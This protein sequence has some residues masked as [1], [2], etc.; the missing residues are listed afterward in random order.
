MTLDL[1]DL[2][3]GLGV[4]DSRYNATLER[5]KQNALGL[6]GI[7]E[8][9]FSQMTTRVSQS[10][11][12][13]GPV[14]AEVERALVHLEQL[15]NYSDIGIGVRVDD[16]ALDA[17]ESRIDSL[18]GRTI[19]LDV[20]WGGDMGDGPMGLPAPRPKLPGGG[21]FDHGAMSRAVADGV[22]EGI[23]RTRSGP[24]SSTIGRLATGFLEE[25]G[26][27]IA[28][29]SGFG[30]LSRGSGRRATRMAK[31]F[32][33]HAMGL[34]E[35][36]PAFTAE[37]LRSGSFTK[38]AKAGYEQSPAA[39]AMQRLAQ[40][41]TLAT[42]D[43]DNLDTDALMSV[44]G[45][46]D[47][48][49]SE[50]IESPKYK[51]RIAAEGFQKVAE[52]NKAVRVRIGRIVADEMK[53]LQDLA[54]TEFIENIINS[55]LGDLR[56]PLSFIAKTR[57]YRNIYE[58]RK[59]APGARALLPDLDEGQDG[60]VQMIGGA[61]F[62]DGEGH[63]Q[64]TA[65]FDAMLPDRRVM[66]VRNPDTDPGGKAKGVVAG[67]LED[68]I[69]GAVPMLAQDEALSNT[70]TNAVTM[71]VNSLNIAGY[72]ETVASALANVMA[73][74]EAGLDPSKF[75]TVSY[76]LGGAN[77]K[78]IAIA[79]ERMGISSPVQA[80]AYPDINPSATAGNKNFKASLIEEDP[81]GFISLLGIGDRS[82]QQI[83][84]SG[85]AGGAEAHAPKHYF[86]NQEQIAEFYRHL[87]IQAPDVGAEEMGSFVDMGSNFYELMGATSQIDSLVR[88]GGFDETLP[89]KAFAGGDEFTGTQAVMKAVEALTV[90]GRF[91]SRNRDGSP[92]SP[93]DQ[94]NL[95]K[96]LGRYSPEQQAVIEAMT[97]HAYT[98]LDSL[99]ASFP[100]DMATI[101]G[102]RPMDPVDIAGGFQLRNIQS[103]REKFYADMSGDEIG[104]SSGF[105]SADRDEARAII[106]RLEGNADWFKKNL[107]ETSQLPEI[108]EIIEEM[109]SA[110]EE[111]ATTGA[112]SDETRAS[113][114]PP[115]IKQLSPEFES[116]LS[117]KVDPTKLPSQQAEFKFDAPQWAYDDPGAVIAYN[118]IAQG[119]AADGV[120]QKLPQ[121]QDI[122]FAAYGMSGAASL[123]AGDYV[124]K[125]DVYDADK[126]ASDQEVAAYEKLAG[127]YAPLLMAHQQ[128]EY[129]VT[130]RAKGAPLK[131]K[132]TEAAG[133]AKAASERVKV[134]SEELANTPKEN[135]EAIKAG[136]Q[137]LSQAKEELAQEKQRFNDYAEELYTKLGQLG[138]TLHSMGVAHM[139]LAAGNAFVGEDGNLSAIDLGNSLVDPTQFQKTVD[140]AT[141]AQRAVIDQEFWGIMDPVR[142]IKAVQAG[143]RMEPLPEQQA[144]VGRARQ[145]PDFEGEKV[146]PLGSE[147]L[148]SIQNYTYDY[149]DRAEQI[150]EQRVKERRAQMIQ[151]PEGLL[152]AKAA[153]LEDAL[154]EK[155]RVQPGKS[156]VARYYRLMALAQQSKNIASGGEIDE[157]LPI[158]GMGEYATP[159]DMMLGFANSYKE[160][161]QTPLTGMGSQ[162]RVLH[163]AVLAESAKAMEQ[164]QALL[165]SVDPGAEGV[166]PGNVES[167]LQFQKLLPEFQELISRY[168]QPGMDEEANNAALEVANGF[169]EVAEGLGDS[170]AHT[171]AIMGFFKSVKLLAKEFKETGQVT[172]EGLDK[173]LYAMEPPHISKGR[174][175]GTTSVRHETRELADQLGW[176]FDVNRGVGF[177]EVS[178]YG[179]TGRP[180]TTTGSMDEA[181]DI[182]RRELQTL[183]K[184]NLQSAIAVETGDS[185]A[186]AVIE[187]KI[188]NLLNGTTDA[189]YSEV[190]LDALDRA[191][192]SRSATML[193]SVQP[194]AVSE[195]FEAKGKLP[196]DEAQAEDNQLV[197]YADEESGIIRRVGELAKATISKEGDPR[198]I[199]RA[200][201]KSLVT[202]ANSM[203]KRVPRR[204]G[205]V[206]ETAKQITSLKDLKITDIAKITRVGAEDANHEALKNILLTI[207]EL[208]GMESAVIGNSKALQTIKA[209][210]QNF[211]V[212]AVMSGAMKVASPEFAAAAGVTEDGLAQLIGN[213]MTH[214]TIGE[215]PPVHALAEGAGWFGKMSHF[216]H[217]L[218]EA[219]A[220]FAYNA[221]SA[222]IHEAVSGPTHLAADVGMAKGAM[223]GSGAG[224]LALTH[225]GTEREIDLAAFDGYSRQQA[226]MD[227][228]R[229]EAASRGRLS[230]PSRK[231]LKPVTKA[232]D[233]KDT[234]KLLRAQVEEANALVEVN[235]EK[236]IASAEMLGD[237][238]DVL[239][240]D[241]QTAFERMKP[242]KR[243]QG[244]GAKFANLK[245]QLNRLQGQI[246]SIRGDAILALPPAAE[247]AS[248][249]TPT[250][251]PGQ[252][253][254]LNISSVTKALSTKLTKAGKTAGKQKSEG[255]RRLAGKQLLEMVE[256]IET[257]IEGLDAQLDP[258]TE[259]PPSYRRELGKLRSKIKSYRKKGGKLVD[260]NT[261]SDNS[262]WTDTSGEI[263]N[264]FVQSVEGDL[265]RVKRAGESLGEALEGG[266][267]ESLEIQS[268]SKVMERLG[269]FAVEGLDK[270]LRGIDGIKHL[271]PE[272]ILKRIQSTREMID[273]FMD[274]VDEK[275]TK[276]TRRFGAAVQLVGGAFAGFKVAQFAAA[277]LA[278]LIGKGIEVAETMER[279]QTS[280]NFAAGGKLEGAADMSFIADEAD[281]LNTNLLAGA[282]NYARL[283]ATNKGTS[284]EGYQT[285]QT[286]A[287]VNQASAVLGL[288][289][290]DTDLTFL[291]L[292]QIAAKSVVS[293]EELRQQLGE[294]LPGAMAIAARSMDMTTEQ[295]TALVENGEI[296]AEDFLPNF[297]AQMLA[298]TASG[299]SAATETTQSKRNRVENAQFELYQAFGQELLPVKKAGLDLTADALGVAAENTDLL[300]SSIK[301][302]GTIGLAKFLQL[303]LQVAGVE[304]GILSLATKAKEFGA[305]ALFDF[306]LDGFRGLGRS[307]GGT[308][309]KLKS[310]KLGLSDV[311][312]LLDSP[313]LKAGVQFAGTAALAY[314]ATE[315]IKATI[316]L[317][318]AM[319][320]K[321]QGAAKEL[322]DAA[323]QLQLANRN[324]RKDDDGD[325]D[326][327]AQRASD[328]ESRNLFSRPVDVLRRFN[329]KNFERF[330]AES[331][332]AR[333]TPRVVKD[334]LGNVN[335]TSG[336]AQ[337]SQIVIE[338]S[339]VADE[340]NEALATVMRNIGEFDPEALD[341][342]ETQLES[343]KIRSRVL[344]AT[345]PL[346]VEAIQESRART[347][348]LQEQ[349]DQLKQPLIE[350]QVAL[351][352]NIEIAKQQ[353]KTLE[354]AL[355]AKELDEPTF[356]AQKSKL[357]NQISLYEKELERL[358]DMMDHSADS[359]LALTLSMQKLFD[360]FEGTI[361]AIE[362]GSKA[363]RIALLT[364]QAA[365]QFTPGQAES[366]SFLIEQE[367]NVQ[368]LAAAE[369]LERNIRAK[370]STDDSRQQLA[371][372]G[373]TGNESTAEL[374]TLV[375]QLQASPKQKAIVEQVARLREAE[376]QAEDFAL[377]VATGMND[378]SQQLRDVNRSVSDYLRDLTREMED[379]S[380]DIER[381]DMEAGA[382][383]FRGELNNAFNG[384]RGMLT[385]YLDGMLDLVELMNEPLRRQ[386]E[387][388]QQQGQIANRLAD[389]ALS[390]Q[391]LLK[392]LPGGSFGG[393]D[394]AA[395]TGLAA[396]S[397]V[398][399]VGNTGT[400]SAA[401]LDI[402]YASSYVDANGLR[403]A[404]GRKPE[405][406]DSHLSRFM[407]GG[408]TLD[409]SDDMVTSG[410]GYRGDIGVVNA[411]KW[412]EGVD[413]G[414][415]EGQEITTTVP[416]KSQRLWKDEAGGGWVNTVE[417]EDGVKVNLL[418]LDPSSQEAIS[419]PSSRVTSQA[420]VGSA[421]RVVIPLDHARGQV[422]DVT[423]GS[424]FKAAGATGASYGGYTE[425]DFQDAIIPAVQANL[426]ARGFEVV[427]MRPEDFSS[428]QAYDERLANLSQQSGT[429]V[430]P[431]HYD[432]L[433]DFSGGYKGGYLTRTRAGDAED[434]RLG[435]FIRQ[436]LDQNVAPG[437][438]SRFLPDDTQSNATINVAA[439]APATLVEFGAMGD[440]VNRFGGLE[441]YMQSAE[442][443]ATV[444]SF[445]SGIS[446]YFGQ[447]PQPSMAPVLAPT[448]R[449]PVAPQASAG[450]TYEQTM[451]LFS[452]NSDSYIAR[453]IG[454]AEGNR[455]ADGGYT[456][457]AEGHEDPGNGAWNVGSF[458]A[459]GSLNR[460]TIEASDRAVIE[461]MLKPLVSEFYQEAQSAGVQVT[462]K[463]LLNYLDAHNQ[464]PL[465]ARSAS[466]GT[467]FL[468]GLEMVRGREND[469]DAIMALRTAMYHSG[470]QYSIA[471]LTVPQDQGR[472]MDELNHA[473][474]AVEMPGGGLASVVPTT[475][476]LAPTTGM[477]QG[478]I[479]QQAQ[480]NAMAAAAGYQVNSANR[481]AIAL[482]NQQVASL[483]ELNGAQDFENRSQV[484]RK[485][486]ELEYQ[487]D[488][489]IFQMQ[490]ERIQADREISDYDLSQ[491]PETLERQRTEN[492]N[493][494]DRREQDFQRNAIRE[495][496][497]LAGDLANAQTG[498]EVIRQGVA[499]GTANPEIAEMIPAL[500]AA[501]AAT[502]QEL[503]SLGE[504]RLK[505]SEQSQVAR[506]SEQ[507]RFEREVAK[508]SY[509]ERSTLNTSDNEVFQSLIDSPANPLNFDELMSFQQQIEASQI[510]L[511]L[512]GQLMQLDEM[513]RT[514]QVTADA[515]AKL[516]DNYRKV[517][518][519][520]MDGL[521]EQLR[522][523][524]EELERA[525]RNMITEADNSFF[526]AVIESPLSK[527]SFNEE[528]SFREQIGRSEIEM[529]LEGQ[530]AQLEQMRS[531][532]RLTEDAAK[533]LEATYRSISQI[534][535]DGLTEELRLQGEEL[536]RNNSTALEES[537]IG[538]LEGRA[539]LKQAVGFSSP[540][541]RQE[542]AKRRQQ[543]KYQEELGELD[544]LIVGRDVN[545][546]EDL[547]QLRANVEALNEIDL[548]AIEAQFSPLTDSIR[549]V[550]EETAGFLV[551]I[552]T[553]ADSLAESFSN[554]LRSIAQSLASNAIN[555]MME[556]WI[557][558][559]FGNRGVGP[560]GT[561]TASGGGVGG[562]IGAGGAIA[563]LFGGGG[564]SA[565]G[566]S[567]L[568]I[569][570]GS[571]IPNFNDG[572]IMG[573]DGRKIKRPVIDGAPYL[574]G[575]GGLSTA[576][577]REATD[578]RIS[579]LKSGE[580]VLDRM[581]TQEYLREK[582]ITHVP[583]YSSGGISGNVVRPSS[584]VGGSG[585]TITVNV[586]V[587]VSGEGRGGGGGE[588]Q[589][590][591][592]LGS[593]LHAQNR[594]SIAEE[595]R[596]G[597]I[598][599]NYMRS[600][601]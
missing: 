119:M 413:Y 62:R 281:R 172:R 244:E 127:R 76:S 277:Q 11:N 533:E 361:E 427:V 439:A 513:L 438:A 204:P 503:E 468:N 457:A 471:G 246:E 556:D 567:D 570:L 560:G 240:Q 410:Y 378:F 260:Q 26:R 21:G 483:K 299:V 595:M 379:I 411:S 298:E 450:L 515:A 101:S 484:K 412:H 51:D 213:M 408:R 419:R 216:G 37:M 161:A 87:G 59:R 592:D 209:L 477:T 65:N 92:L 306:K 359:A 354:S 17:L 557:G 188:D 61:M 50:I 199:V 472:R 589:L 546:Q 95:Q 143:Y 232:G 235:Q 48:L 270:S 88:T 505:V 339:S 461:E 519:V 109:V 414:F 18:Q 207:A 511:G 321:Q 222:L 250:I 178:L 353:I 120:D 211:V 35:S 424:T 295:F 489:S 181:A 395:P 68:I 599:Y 168:E 348:S 42:M 186:L 473:L 585:S 104:Q 482:G 317:L 452:G 502:E 292:D 234:V 440:H 420:G 103:I 200:V 487:L 63:E 341:R 312:G 499:S 493:T 136:Q 343:S 219:P 574:H 100:E 436:E 445:G 588:Q 314:G 535:L 196:A 512:E 460:G 113:L 467:T 194:P 571:L 247:T 342:A 265:D 212:P 264:G 415:A 381:N 576:L 52:T 362:R 521:T 290:D 296:L 529:G 160:L 94:E 356:D 126:I 182:M 122:D 549:T 590:Q 58:G 301:V 24:I 14:K 363:S 400:G 173:A 584:I 540:A 274:G 41:Q 330:E 283:A 394:G 193:E 432:A 331:P 230:G 258:E 553:G 158:A 397:T 238:V 384:Q 203:L 433:E 396:G 206:D 338:T 54:P 387:F 19:Y 56:G 249:A 481:Q 67:F 538:V 366:Q 131:D 559:L 458:S 36:L 149:R 475:S 561:A 322:Q 437:T 205:V 215:A 96:R 446:R 252:I 369:T 38:A 566:S 66:G 480:F 99:N 358:N 144:R 568:A 544:K 421:G 508:R 537:S 374:N 153:W 259:R 146:V 372:I 47:R 564:A 261:E 114:V 248:A 255:D 106:S 601:R 124:Y 328:T 70:V 346:D 335:T 291:A 184:L 228:K 162:E 25:G 385:E 305:G 332:L 239:L 142:Q 352:S 370:L 583:N 326:S 272:A 389:M 597:G 586:P 55:A 231:A 71:A 81:L 462:P 221:K 40:M 237:V 377:Q 383:R 171:T 151:E 545:S 534:S 563:S 134:L 93:E 351:D 269:A 486:L 494:I 453:A 373:I 360:G 575:F 303:G 600:N 520:R 340:M 541:L 548:S 558:G 565:A 257:A 325:G 32:N 46:S 528:A 554:M 459:Q 523:Q 463:L 179:K 456:W 488:E 547:D 20:R 327:F 112:V 407:V 130:E 448:I 13:E 464:S 72:S 443:A 80:I 390:Q 148:T 435:S 202:Q 116:L 164:V 174:D 263:V 349:R 550:K 376:K 118:K 57:G 543:I 82:N 404:E 44:P 498:L 399:V 510:D 418:H 156:D 300:V 476:P 157:T 530:L 108:L 287:S 64:L 490:T 154:D 245:G 208:Q 294:R 392:T 253:K 132:L 367:A 129:L 150:R 315:G 289:Q 406:S 165:A 226:A 308:V 210:G 267:R 23:R 465:A 329:Q 4:D 243:T 517:A 593:K 504:S 91:R 302:L 333:F 526:N 485:K 175:K 115:K 402:R 474:Q 288:T 195:I 454:M 3:L 313:V 159:G 225:E 233:A 447:S 98:A 542:A 275:S 53:G 185:D 169:K 276:R 285:R 405:I 183:S 417:F 500:E 223:H 282:S 466:S 551:D 506:D 220:Q 514:S 27:Q 355:A 582:A 307:I 31:N 569:G 324:L 45:V 347:D 167:Y 577:G 197:Q 163:D 416:V 293:M 507:A 426:E 117:Q 7:I 85:V 442:A 22:T 375:E 491:G 496:K 284:L 84:K 495:Q 128:G 527:L 309:T 268:P 479:D 334:V 176:D 279:V 350:A 444:N 10:L 166:G 251:E 266:V 364:R 316:D 386:I 79:F 78:D 242:E 16:S 77:A 73:A 90:M 430:T 297:S 434:S 30:A 532:N 536:R 121:I 236:A 155:V 180:I 403:T 60:Y 43:K 125:T 227:R 2:M 336:E 401:H 286:F 170:D 107:K 110:L 587:N 74:S 431:I 441:G 271:I 429:V 425:R 455:T 86:K 391:D 409:Q 138:A 393:V 241:V 69:K 135:K 368:S 423:G 345:D 34:E 192:H 9:R 198:E 141:T 591:A 262:D 371:D 594:E 201:E 524:R 187:Q 39:K 451:G 344:E 580:M 28:A 531:E 177:Q 8:S 5:A 12:L 304:V 492:L 478:T 382:A 318:D 380:Y 256:A 581:E 214:A 33:T 133:P 278:P 6:A 579:V 218:A 573:S 145:I 525:Q 152:N 539:D 509:E 1:G 137:L 224:A 123:I 516:E 217:Q 311:I 522:L 398:G 83:Y 501:I 598:I 470:N 497:R 89:Y 29:G 190:D 323:K 229:L 562:L 337:V 15:K 140:E 365:G 388:Q 49:R 280:L 578:Q 310:A 254:Q 102:G 449:T 273:G 75:G 572:G 105:A 422:P 596:P 555:A 428:Y 147:T 518:T 357:D 469:D 191:A 320:G 319:R 139:D 97:T 552:A 189:S 111:Y